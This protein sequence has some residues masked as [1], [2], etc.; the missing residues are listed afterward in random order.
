[1]GDIIYEYKSI[2]GYNLD[3]LNQMMNELGRKGFKLVSREAH[4]AH[5]EGWAVPNM[6]IEYTIVM[7]R[8]VHKFGYNRNKNRNF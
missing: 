2:V 3:K 8:E 4:T 1:M 5:T 6:V 7:Q